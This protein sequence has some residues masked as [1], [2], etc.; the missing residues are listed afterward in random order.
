MGSRSNSQCGGRGA[1]QYRAII[2][3]V[4]AKNANGFFKEFYFYTFVK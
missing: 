3:N 1:Q 2:L 4:G